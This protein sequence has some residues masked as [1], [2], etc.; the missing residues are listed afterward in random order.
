MACAKVEKNNYTVE[1]LRQWDLNRVLTIQGLSLAMAPE[2]HFAHDSDKL[3]VVRQSTMDESGVVSVTV[4][5]ALLEKPL[6]LNVYICSREGDVF[7]TLF[8]MVIPV[9]KRAMPSDWDGATED[10]IYSLEA[11]SAEVVMVPSTEGATVEKVLNKDGT[12]TLKFH[13]PDKGAT[14]AANAASTSATSAKTAEHNA[15]EAKNTAETAAQSAE[16]SRADAEKSASTAEESASQAE[17][18]ANQAETSASDASKAKSSAETSASN[19]EQS[20]LQAKNSAINASESASQAGTLAT[21]AANSASNA[22]ESA[23]HASKSASNAETSATEAEQSA[24][25]AQDSVNRIEN[26]GVQASMLP[27]D[28]AATVEKQIDKDGITLLFGIPNGKSAYQYAVDSGYT[29]TEKEFMAKL[30]AE[31]GIF[32]VADGG[33]PDSVDTQVFDGGTPFT[34]DEIKLDGGMP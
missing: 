26:M 34:T 1:P 29:G 8:H 30:A 5:N 19:A 9:D 16:K 7:K 10:E 33:T 24:Q 32:Y 11:L 21:S 15:V 14:E 17:T 28:S 13:I 2:I 12:W 6:R 3:A 23:D 20:A 4:P 22:Q 27:P 18:S 25:Q 31:A